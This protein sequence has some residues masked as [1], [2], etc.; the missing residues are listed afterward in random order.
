MT[1]GGVSVGAGDVNADGKAYVVAGAGPG[2]GPNVAIFSG[3]NAVLLQ[4]YFAFN[5]VFSGGVFVAT[6]DI[7]H[8]GKADIIAGT[9]A[10]GGPNV[11]VFS[12]SNGALLQSFFAFDP[13]FTG[14]VRVGATAF[15]TPARSVILTGAG[16][17]GGPQIAVLDPQ[18]QAPLDSFFAFDPGFNGGVFVGGE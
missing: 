14:G 6:G 2:G 11:A 16:A 10:G 18:S 17:G 8:D 7:N 3:A 4:S 5:A 12:G 15:G 1:T 9:G 13:A